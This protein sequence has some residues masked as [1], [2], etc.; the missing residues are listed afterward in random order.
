MKKRLFTPIVLVSLIFAC[1]QNQVQPTAQRTTS[2][3]FEAL[4]KETVALVQTDPIWQSFT[5]DKSFSQLSASFNIHSFSNLKLLTFKNSDLKCI[6]IPIS[7]TELGNVLA[8][9]F[10]K[11]DGSYQTRIFA[12]QITKESL[13]NLKNGVTKNIEASVLTN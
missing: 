1:S 2:T 4:V 13:Q 12:T 5:K 8:F 7:T 11:T 3:S 10:L 6:A 9:A